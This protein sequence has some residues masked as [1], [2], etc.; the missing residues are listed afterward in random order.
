MERVPNKKNTRFDWPDPQCNI[1]NS[2]KN[3]DVTIDEEE[4][5]RA[6]MSIEN[7]A[8]D[9]FC[10]ENNFSY[11]PVPLTKKYN[12]SESFMATIVLGSKSEDSPYQSDVNFRHGMS[13]F[14]IM[15]AARLLKK[16][17][18][19]EH[20]NATGLPAKSAVSW[21]GNR[22]DSTLCHASI[23]QQRA[24]GEFSSFN[25]TN[26]NNSTTENSADETQFVM[27]PY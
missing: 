20:R 21:N 13:E 7:S 5:L 14:L 27:D 10:A 9:D 22:G 11:D 4:A 25:S 6:D 23:E 17:S 2:V 24:M 16:A 26:T 3:R 12:L 15:Q 8:F 19:P 1:S 18:L